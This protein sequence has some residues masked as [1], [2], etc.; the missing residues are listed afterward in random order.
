MTRP[1]KGG[2]PDDGPQGGSALSDCGGVSLDPI[3]HSSIV[4][5][6]AAS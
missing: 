4:V 5:S 2:K 3:Y 1:A 6:E